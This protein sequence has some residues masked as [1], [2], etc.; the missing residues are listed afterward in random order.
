[1]RSKWAS[2]EHSLPMAQIHEESTRGGIHS[3]ARARQTAAGAIMRSWPRADDF[4]DKGNCTTVYSTVVLEGGAGRSRSPC[5][6][7]RGRLATL[8]PTLKGGMDESPAQTWRAWP[9]EDCCLHGRTM[10]PKKHSNAVLCAW[11]PSQS[12]RSLVASAANIVSMLSACSNGRRKV[13]PRTMGVQHVDAGGQERFRARSRAL[14]EISA[15]SPVLQAVLHGSGRGSLWRWCHGQRRSRRR[16]SGIQR[17]E[18]VIGRRDWPLCTQPMTQRPR[19]AKKTTK[20]VSQTTLKISRSSSQKE[21]LEGAN[22]A[23]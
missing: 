3:D 7:G 19:A 2:H 13:S 21:R 17:T 14:R 22:G 20:T 11:S 12:L 16:L 6:R 18:S 23:R 4:Y 15:R 5:A 1:M 9:W 8:Q 10:L